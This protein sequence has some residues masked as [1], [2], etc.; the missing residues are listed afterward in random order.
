MAAIAMPALDLDGDGKITSA[1][2][3]HAFV[4]VY[5]EN[6]NLAAC[7]RD[8]RAIVL[9]L[10]G[11]LTTPLVVV[12]LFV[13]LALSGIDVQ[14]LFLSLSSIIVACAFMFSSTLQNLV[15]S[16]TF[17]FVT[18]PFDVGDKIV[19]DGRTLVVR[20][21]AL[22]ST[23]FE[24]DDD[25][26]IYFPNR[27][28]VTKDLANIRRSGSQW[29]GL[30]I[31]VDW[32]TP[33]AKLQQFERDMRAQLAAQL[34]TEFFPSFDLTITD[35]KL[36]SNSL[37]INIWAQQRTNWQDGDKWAARTKLL[38]LMRAIFDKLEIR[39]APPATRVF[40]DSKNA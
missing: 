33:S 15:E 6:R 2:M 22:L 21:I 25:S 34:A 40:L 13:L 14:G 16:L 11:I 26:V 35:A 3:T 12:M 37:A 29:H 1:E 7:V 5:H 39:Y 27:I 24:A 8:S 31:M 30:T 17:L 19:V 38:L 28:L 18:H 9:K 23:T 36:E 32:H 4:N 10:D 20:K